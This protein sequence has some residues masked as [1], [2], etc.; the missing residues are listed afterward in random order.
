[1]KKRP[2]MAIRTEM[3]RTAAARSAKRSCSSARRPKRV[4]S[5]APETPNRSVMVAD[6]SPLSCICSRVSPASLAPT[7]R[8]GIK[9][10]GSMTSAARVSC[11]LSTDMATRTTTRLITFDNTVERVEVNACW[12]PMTSELSRDTSLPVWVRVK[13]A[14]GIWITWSNTWVRRS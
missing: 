4:T 5:R 11:Q 1:M 7:I 13:K 6:R 10:T 14:T 3:S 9:K 8:A 2:F 12:A